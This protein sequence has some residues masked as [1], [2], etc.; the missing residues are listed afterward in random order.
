MGRGGELTK[1]F[2][3]GARDVSSTPLTLCTTYATFMDD[4]V[5]ESILCTLH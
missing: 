1:K 4:P 3:H 2:I 5:C